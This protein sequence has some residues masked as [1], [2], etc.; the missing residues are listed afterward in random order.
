MIQGGESSFLIEYLAV[1]ATYTASQLQ[2]EM[3][4]V[5]ISVFI[6]ACVINGK[7]WA[8]ILAG[9]MGSWLFFFKSIFLLL[10]FIALFGGILYKGI[11]NIEKSSI[12]H[13]IMAM[14]VFEIL[15]IGFIRLYYLQELKDMLFAAEY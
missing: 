6:M 7:K 15:L 9:V 8:V 12:V 1:L 11:K 10:L 4:C 3:T 5:I 13:V 14:A 2:V